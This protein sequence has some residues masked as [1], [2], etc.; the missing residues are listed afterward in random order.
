[1]ELRKLT[2]PD[3]GVLKYD[4]LTALSVVGLHGTPTQQTSMLRLIALITARYNWRRDELSVG[5]RE[6]ARMWQVNERTVKRE[7]KRLVEGGWLVCSRPGVRGRV[8]AY[9]LNHGRISALSEPV[10]GAVGPDFQARMEQ[11][12]GAKAPVK[13]VQLSDYVPAPAPEENAA[14]WDK[15]MARAAEMDR[16]VHS[17]WFAKLAF[18]SC[19]GG[20]LRLKAPSAFVARYVETHHLPALIGA[21]EPFFGPLDTLEF[22]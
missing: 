8:A 10:W 12:H 2:G 18:V 16:G 20:A 9:R 3:A 14:P 7:V 15:A 22:Q 17:A 11:R 1:M 13:V 21:A 5:Q 19:E 6:M 4:V